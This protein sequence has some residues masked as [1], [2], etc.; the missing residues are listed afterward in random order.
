M[1]NPFGTTPYRNDD[2]SDDGDDD[3][4]DIRPSGKL[5]QHLKKILLT[6]TLGT[7]DSVTLTVQF[8]DVDDDV[9]DKEDACSHSTF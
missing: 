6:W 8:D 7:P 9:V 4:D 2:D 3:Y 1:N 5:P